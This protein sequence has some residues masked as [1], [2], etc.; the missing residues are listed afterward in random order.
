[1]LY[2]QNYKKFLKNAVFVTLISWVLTLLVL[3][4]TFGPIAATLKMG[5]YDLGFM[6]FMVAVVASISIKAALIDPFAMTALMQVFFK[7]TE[8]QEPNPEW[9][10]KLE[11]GS[12]KFREMKDKAV[13]WASSKFSGGGKSSTDADLPPQA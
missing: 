7:V 2:A 5:N 11:K 1:M 13:S 12:K 3:A 6:P 8:G 10:A 9:E 4:L